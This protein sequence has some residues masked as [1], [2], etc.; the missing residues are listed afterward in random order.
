MTI[1]IIPNASFRD[2]GRAINTVTTE[3]FTKE[4]LFIK[5]TMMVVIMKDKRGFVKKVIEKLKTA[6]KL[7]LYLL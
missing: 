4:I 6:W 2:S 5:T 7:S 3:V 1:A